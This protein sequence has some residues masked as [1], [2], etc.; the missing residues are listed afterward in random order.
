MSR[1]TI[2][3]FELFQAVSDLMDQLQAARDSNPEAFAKFSVEICGSGFAHACLSVKK[4]ITQI[5]EGE[6]RK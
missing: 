4:V 5:V 2:S 6:P 1:S 3:T